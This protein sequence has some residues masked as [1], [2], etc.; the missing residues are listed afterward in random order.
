MAEQ[1]L[2]RLAGISVSELW[3]RFDRQNLLAQFPGKEPKEDRHRREAGYK[4]HES[5]G[6]C[7]PLE[8][9]RAKPEPAK[10][11]PPAYPR[12]ERTVEFDLEELRPEIAED[13]AGLEDEDE[14]EAPRDGK[15]E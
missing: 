4:L 9:A 15:T 13:L 2:A 14:E 12:L 5:T 11:K 3:E 10:P 6:D 1:R 7:F 8:P